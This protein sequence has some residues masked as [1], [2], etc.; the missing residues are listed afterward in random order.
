TNR[1]RS[2]DY[3]DAITSRTAAI[4]RVHTS[5]YRVSGFTESVSLT[6]M[7]AVA[8]RHDVLLIDDLGS[9][10]AEPMADEPTVAESLR[11]SDVVT[12]SGDKLFGGPQAGFVVGRGELLSRL[13]AHPVARVVRPGKLTLAALAATLSAWKREK[14]RE[15]PVYRAAAQ[16]L[17]EL[18][19][20][21]ESI[22][23]ALATSA[24]GLRLDVVPSFAL[25]GGGTSPEKKFPSRALALAHPALAPEALLAR[26]RESEP[27]VVARIEDD[28]V[29]LDMRS[30]L[31]E[32]DTAVAAALVSLA[33]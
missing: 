28:R 9:G 11:L 20:R 12:F 29:L 16:S 10:A 7:E 31:P 30:I 24:P 32:E 13:A 26:L 8:R 22:R 25:F 27:A 23:A 18:E 21:A 5:N 1:T 4:L 6:D 14:W 33:R 19:R 15:F 3:E 2:A 17:E